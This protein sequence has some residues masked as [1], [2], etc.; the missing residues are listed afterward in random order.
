MLFFLGRNRYDIVLFLLSVCVYGYF[1]LHNGTSLTGYYTGDEPH[2]VVLVKSL[3]EGHLYVENV[4]RDPRPEWASWPYS[5]HA[6]EG[7]DGHISIRPMGSGS[8]FSLSH[9]TSLRVSLG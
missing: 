4:Y 7:P 9:F 6:V 8:R 1:S 5:W 2:Y 3:A